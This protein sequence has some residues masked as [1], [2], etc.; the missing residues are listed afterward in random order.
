M[1]LMHVPC[2]N[3][4]KMEQSDWSNRQHKYLYNILC[5]NYFLMFQ[6]LFQNYFVR[7]YISTNVYPVTSNVIG[8]VPID[9][10]ISEIQ[11]KQFRR[12]SEN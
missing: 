11:L 9:T 1:M 4:S 10:W 6:L 12:I 7:F 2:I 5:R 8:G 3:N